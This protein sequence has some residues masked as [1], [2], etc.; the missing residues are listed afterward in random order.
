MTLG[1]I[2]AAA[3]ES[4]RFGSESKLFS[5]VNGHTVLYWTLQSLV[6]I[7][8]QHPFTDFIVM[9]HPDYREEFQ[10][11]LAECPLKATMMEGCATRAE[12]VHKAVSV[13]K[14]CDVVFIHDAARPYVSENVFKDSLTAITACD[15]VIPGLPVA[16]TIKRVS[17]NSVV[18]TV[19]RS[20]LVA[21]QTP[22]F[23]K[24][25]A[26]KQAY[27]TVNDWKTATD[28][29]NICEKAGLGVTV[30]PGDKKSHKITYKEDLDYLSTWLNMS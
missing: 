15:A 10:R 24:Y 30:V 26:L 11:H 1:G 22:Q 16:D 2:L 19:D 29:A 8:M 23:F 20:E 13:L 21:V 9:V 3:G 4:R 7:S 12:T 25:E 18:E 17:K 27:L 28:E 14:P 5:I 6:R